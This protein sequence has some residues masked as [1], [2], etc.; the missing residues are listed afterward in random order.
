MA[1]GCVWGR[2]YEGCDFVLAVFRGRGTRMMNSSEFQ[3]EECHRMLTDQVDLVYPE[4]RRIVIGIRKPLPLGG[5]PGQD[6]SDF[7]FKKHYTIVSKPRVV[8]YRDIN[9]QKK[10]MRETKVHKFSDGMLNNILEKLDHIVKD[11]M[12]FKY[13]PGMTIRIWSGDD[14]RRSKEFM[15]VINHK[16]KLQRIFKSLESFN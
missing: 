8:I 1:F 16:L 10:M 7:K 13:N 6:A 12:L 2:V 9:D 11:F 15:E 5:P 4:G 3:M 14:R